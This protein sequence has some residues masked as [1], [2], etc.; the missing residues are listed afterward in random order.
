VLQDRKRGARGQSAGKKN[1]KYPQNDSAA[2]PA[3]G[4][5]LQGDAKSR[6]SPEPSTSV[7]MKGLRFE[8]GRRLSD[9][10]APDGLGCSLRA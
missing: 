5:D 1:R 6:K 4:A 2:L 10:Q 3:E 7:V 8:S 9:G